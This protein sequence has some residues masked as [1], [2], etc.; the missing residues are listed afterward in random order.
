MFSLSSSLFFGVTNTDPSDADSRP[1]DNTTVRSLAFIFLIL[2]SVFAV[3]IAVLLVW[4]RHH[5]F[6]KSR[7][8]P[9]S[10][11]SLSGM[12][13]CSS[14]I[15][16][17]FIVG[18]DVYPCPVYSVAIFFITPTLLGTLLL[19][20]FRVL[21]ITRVSTYKATWGRGKVASRGSEPST[22]EITTDDIKKWARFGT[23]RFLLLLLGIMFLIHGIIMVV[24]FPSVP[25]LR[26]TFRD[27][28]GCYSQRVIS[29]ITAVQFFS[30]IAAIVVA[31]F[32]LRHV[33][34][35]FNLT[36]TAYL[37]FFGWIAVLVPYILTSQIEGY[38]RH[39]EHTAWPS[40]LFVVM[41]IMAD[42][43][44][45]F[46]YPLFKTVTWNQTAT[47]E[48]Q[49]QGKGTLSNEMTQ[50]LNDGDEGF[51]TFLDFCK[52]QFTIENI[53]FWKEVQEFK[54]S[55]SDEARH[56]FRHI[57]NTY[58]IRD[59]PLSLNMP[60]QQEDWATK[61]FE[62]LEEGKA[63]E[64]FDSLLTECERNMLDS[65]I[66]FKQSQDYVRHLRVMQQQDIVLKEIGIN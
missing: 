34:E 48:L 27:F 55:S 15:S 37:T 7:C 36:R 11:V 29:V 18:R 31:G 19:R 64:V 16:L 39:V 25:A 57:V 6:I 40:A 21:I 3:L 5:P 38:Q 12:W 60:H 52:R 61:E 65:F 56:Q 24:A 41:G 44:I 4:K 30:Y 66:R 35:E 49:Q 9:I 14:M 23:D 2:T 63:S 8:L 43:A 17:R 58:L 42:S 46:V 1:T 20:M 62:S 51:N 47:R 54:K 10:L 13:F 22:T 28:S 33:K 45:N 32:L 59:A 50:F 26:R 53:L